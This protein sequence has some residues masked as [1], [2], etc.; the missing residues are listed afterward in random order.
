LAALLSTAS[1][2]VAELHVEALR[3]SVDDCI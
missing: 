3:K 2:N 1:R